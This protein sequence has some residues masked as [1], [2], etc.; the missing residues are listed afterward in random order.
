MAEASLRPT[1]F[2]IPSHRSFADSLVAG[3]IRQ[4]GRDP[5]ALARGRILLPNNRAVRTLT[6]AFVRASEGGLLL[7]RLVAIGDP[8]LD[9]RI[10]G[11]LEAADLSEPLAPAIDPLERQMLL[12]AMLREAGEGA[13]EAM[14]LAADFAR[15][16][17]ALLVEEVTPERLRD[18]RPLAP[19]LAT[20]WQAALTRFEAML[21]R[22]PRELAERGLVDLATRR[23]ASPSRRG[24]PPRRRPS[25]S[26]SRPWRDCPRAWLF[27]PG[28]LSPM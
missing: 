18:A 22:W 19:D 1:V 6:E 23:R 2:T 24:S 16:L 7:P 4:H 25:R 10:G 15:A 17:D 9:D 28:L 13:A 26:W 12:A 8:E 3:L 21:K 5:A 11:A 27:C 14:R 20:H